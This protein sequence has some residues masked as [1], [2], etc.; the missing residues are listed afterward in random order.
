LVHIENLWQENVFTAEGR[1][2]HER[3]DASQ[4]E[5]RGDMRIARGALLRSLVLGLIGK[6]DVI[7]FHRLGETVADGGAILTGQSGR[8]RAFPVEYKR[9]ARRPEHAYEVQLCAQALCI[10]EM[11]STSVP[12]GALYF[13]EPHRRLDVVFD[14]GLRAE[15]RD[16]AARFHRLFHSGQTP[17]A[18]Y[19][20]K[21]RSCSMIDS[22]VPRAAEGRKSVSRYLARVIADAHREEG[23]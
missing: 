17:P 19:G 1:I 16:A 11:L 10:E 12:A 14:K 15:T 2:L 21:C 7:E 8:W 4:T 6:A 5:S 9:G 3:S 22:C 20:P 13:G 23:G 18:H